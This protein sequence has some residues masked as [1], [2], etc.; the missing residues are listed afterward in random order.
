MLVVVNIQNRLALPAYYL[1]YSYEKK[2]SQIQHFLGILRKP[3]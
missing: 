3:N 2:N 1:F